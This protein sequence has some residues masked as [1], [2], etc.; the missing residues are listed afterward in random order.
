MK[1]ILVTGLILS[2]IG[3]AVANDSPWSGKGQLGFSSTSGNSDTS[4]LTAG[5]AG[6]YE[7]NQWIHTVSLDVLRADANGID[8]A[9]RYII[10]GKSGYKFS[11]K[12]YVFFNTR[13][14]RDSFTAFDYTWT[15]AVGWGHKFYDN[16]DKKLIT[17]IGVGHKIAAFDIDRNENSGLVVTGKMDYMRKISD[18]MS[19]DDVLRVEATS[20]NTFIQNDAGFTFKVSD[21]MGVKLSHQWRHNTDVPVGT[22]N[23]DTLV[24]A[25]L[26]YDF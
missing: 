21:K 18:N 19:F 22:N 6:K 12:D 23:T 13:Y 20:N 16:D 26:V 7:V 11:E 9:K 5:I 8:T 24:A 17:E 15:N 2:T 1:K 14:E 10:E 4:T 25:S 3:T